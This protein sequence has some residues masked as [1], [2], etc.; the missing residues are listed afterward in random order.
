MLEGEQEPQLEELI[1]LVYAELHRQAHNYLRREYK[2]RTFQTTE[3]INEAYLKL[4]AQKDLKFESRTH[5]FAIASN[6]MRQILVDHART[7]HR[8]KRGGPQS[9]LPL[10]EAL[11]VGADGMDLDLVG[12][13]DALKRLEKLD[14]QQARIVELKYFGGLSIQETA[15]IVGISPATVKRDWNLARIWLF[16]ELSL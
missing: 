13:D 4:R 1:P 6:L 16:N 15:D 2:N 14:A 5:F 12:L 10:D 3:L 7:K 8:L 11:H 9:D